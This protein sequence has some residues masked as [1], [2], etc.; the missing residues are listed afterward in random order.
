MSAMHRC[1]SAKRVVSGIVGLLCNLFLFAVKLCI[2]LA[3]ASISIA[4]D[5]VNNLSD[6]LSSL[7]SVIGFKLA[8]K[9]PDSKHPF[10]Y[11]RTEYLAGLVVAFLIGMVG[12]EF[13]KSSLDRILHP[14]AVRFSLPLMVILA[15]SM[16]VK[17]WLGAFNHQFGTR[18]DSTVLMAARQ[19]S[20][21]DVITTSVVLIGMVI[22]QFTTIPVD[23]YIG[24]IVAAF[25]LL[26]RR[27]H[28]PRY[29]QP[30]H[31]AG[32]RP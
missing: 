32:C 3:T 29:A 24:L 31:R 19:D 5:A 26:L 20:I 14:A 13:A 9:A 15:L 27:R 6:G 12:I 1:A 10:G 18:I 25:I 28:C 16:L 2:G 21:N 11:G 17:L 8:G 7:I 4:A 23:G 22:S 30:A